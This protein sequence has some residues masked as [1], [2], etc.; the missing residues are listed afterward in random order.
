MNKKQYKHRLKI[1][2]AFSQIN[3][4]RSSLNLA[5]KTNKQH[6]KFHKN[7]DEDWKMVTLDNVLYWG[8]LFREAK[9]RLRDALNEFRKLLQTQTNDI[10]LPF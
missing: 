8:R 4:L 1:L 10:D 2:E 9:Q 7:A 5:N 6:I 3:T